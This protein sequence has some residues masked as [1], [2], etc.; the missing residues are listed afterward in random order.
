VK[1]LRS[2]L[3]PAVSLLICSG[4][5]ACTCAAYDVYVGQLW[6]T[7]LHAVGIRQRSEVAPEIMVAAGHELSIH[8]RTHTLKQLPAD[9][10]EQ[11]LAWAGI[12]L[13]DGWLAFQGQTLENVVTEFN[14]HNDRQL[15]IGDVATGQLRVG[16]KF[17]VTDVDGFVAALAVTH[18]VRAIRS[19]P[20]GNQP[21]VILLLAGSS[22]SASP[23]GPAARS[24]D[25]N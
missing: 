21:R 24:Q 8:G 12:H 5:L 18:G 4:V 16:G 15:V 22:G 23:E 3:K 9:E 17:R 14:R 11:R 19:A 25:F 20:A 13:K 2:H 1:L 10:L 6:G 7:L